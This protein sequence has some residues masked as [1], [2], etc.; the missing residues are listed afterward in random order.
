LVLTFLKRGL[1]FFAFFLA[2]IGDVLTEVSSPSLNISLHIL[3]SFYMFPY[4]ISYPS[5][6]HASDSFSTTRLSIG[7][8]FFCPD[9]CSPPASGQPRFTFPVCTVAVAVVVLHSLSYRLHVLFLT[10][11]ATDQVIAKTVVECY[12]FLSLFATILLL[13]EFFSAKVLPMTYYLLKIILASLSL[14]LSLFVCLFVLF[15][16]VCLFCDC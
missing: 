14:S 13:L 3:C 2:F 6:I 10:T 11:I 16:F 4:S 15:C 1:C 5:V 9:H 8:G 12:H 7:Q